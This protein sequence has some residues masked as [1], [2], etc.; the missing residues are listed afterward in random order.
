MGKNSLQVACSHLT[1]KFPDY[2][3]PGF[4]YPHSGDE[5]V[6]TKTIAHSNWKL[7]RTCGL[8]MTA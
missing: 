3:Y 1:P 2:E 8:R 6:V 7:F 5:T 4:R